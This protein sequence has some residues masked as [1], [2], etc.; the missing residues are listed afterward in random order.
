MGHDQR[1]KEL[2]RLFRRPFL[3]H[4]FP[5]IAGHLDL[6]RPEF[7]D[8][9]LFEDPPEGSHRVADLVAR[10]TTREGEPEMLLV[11]IEV[12]ADRKG[13]VPA[14]MVDYYAL[15]RRMYRLRLFLSSSTFGAAATA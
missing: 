12:Q 5:D 6:S 8:K 11:H 4:F 14:R 9:E 2:L 15:L 1:F 13:D 10:V 3:E 7:V